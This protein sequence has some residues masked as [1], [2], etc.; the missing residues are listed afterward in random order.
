MRESLGRSSKERKA[1]YSDSMSLKEL[2]GPG[3]G[4]LPSKKKGM[5]HGKKGR[6]RKS[7]PTLL[8]KRLPLPVYR[9]LQR[10]GKN[11][12]TLLKQVNR[13]VKASAKHVLWF[14]KRLAKYQKQLKRKKGKTNRKVR[15]EKDRTFL[16]GKTR[17]ECWKE[18]QKRKTQLWQVVVDYE[19]KEKE[20]TK[21]QAQQAR[22]AQLEERQR[23]FQ[24]KMEYLDTWDVLPQA[25]K[26]T[27][28]SLSH[29]LYQRV[30][31]DPPPPRRSSRGGEEPRSMYYNS[32]PMTPSSMLA[33]KMPNWRRNIQ[34]AYQSTILS[35]N[36]AG[37]PEEHPLVKKAARRTP[38]P[39][40]MSWISPVLEQH[41]DRDWLCKEQGDDPMPYQVG[42]LVLY[43]P[44]AHASFLKV[45]PDHVGHSNSD[46]PESIKLSRKPLWEQAMDAQSRRLAARSRNQDFVSS[47]AAEG[48]STTVAE[49][50]GSRISS[51][52][53]TQTETPAR[54]IPLTEV[55]KTSRRDAN[56]DTATRCDRA[57][58]EHPIESATN[59]RQSQRQRERTARGKRG[60]SASARITQ[61]DADTDLIRRT[62]ELQQKKNETQ[63]VQR[64]SV[65]QSMSEASDTSHPLQRQVTKTRPEKRGR[66]AD[67]RLTTHSGESNGSADNGRE[68]R[69]SRFQ[70]TFKVPTESVRDLFHGAAVSAKIGTKKE[71]ML[72]L[73]Q[74]KKR[75]KLAPRGNKLSSKVKGRSKVS[76]RKIKKLVIKVGSKR[77]ELAV[78]KGPKKQHALKRRRVESDAVDSSPDGE[79]EIGDFP[80]PSVPLE[81]E[82]EET[83]LDEEAAL[84]A[85][86]W[87]SKD[88]LNGID[89]DLGRYPILCR[90]EQSHAEFPQDPHKKK[91]DKH[92]NVTWIISQTSASRMPKEPIRLCLKLKPLTPVMPPVAKGDSHKLPLPPKFSVVTFPSSEAQSFLIPFAEAF[93]KYHSLGVGDTVAG[94]MNGKVAQ[95]AS[96]GENFGSFQLADKVKE[97]RG[98]LQQLEKGDTSSVGKCLGIDSASLLYEEDV[99]FLVEALHLFMEN[100]SLDD[101]GEIENLATLSL[102]DILRSCFPLFNGIGIRREAF[103]RKISY[104]SAWDLDHKKKPSGSFGESLRDLCHRHLARGVQSYLPMPLRVR[105]RYL[106]LDFLESRPEAAGFSKAIALEDA[107]SYN[108]AV[109]VAMYFDRILARLNNGK[110][111]EN[112]YYTSVESILSDIQAVMINCRVYNSRDSPLVTVCS[113]LVPALKKSVALAFVNSVRDRARKARTQDTQN[114]SDSNALQAISAKSIV[115]CFDVLKRRALTGKKIDHCDDR[116]RLDAIMSGS[117][118]SVYPTGLRSLPTFEDMLLPRIDVGSAGVG[119]RGVRRTDDDEAISTLS[120]CLFLPPWSVDT[121]IDNPKQQTWADSSKLCLELVRLRLKEQYYSGRSELISEL[122]E[123]YLI[124]STSVLSGPASRKKKGISAQKVAYHLHSLSTKTSLID[125][126]DTVPTDN[127]EFTNEDE[128]V[129][130]SRLERAQKLYT[131]VG[132]RVQLLSFLF[133]SLNAPSFRLCRPFLL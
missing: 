106:I 133:L 73:A 123:A 50:G 18:L 77:I 64:S 107:P 47:S 65:K 76:I 2:M 95:I 57:A 26:E 14:E 115:R 79:S 101:Q 67:A 68:A 49:E 96:L 127:E 92:G 53:P 39:S 131:M 62:P 93:A 6:P 58:E 54:T 100:E 9:E 78:P 28:L 17:Q 27:A 120:E 7:G 98:L 20:A 8:D 38:P 19:R 31:K 22:Q 71:K 51:E 60:H 84:E 132:S 81:D 5:Q 117:I 10:I 36:S 88:W 59:I 46:I 90:I 12:K 85:E 89:S 66:S 114:D 108:C 74:M 129:L 40:T 52:Q 13:Q 128:K 80:L 48:V 112:I 113:S 55:T 83:D 35:Q 122:R 102:L 29:D 69:T 16:N 97:I 56:N 109:P 82:P 34:L 11:R 75:A 130:L 23:Q 33:S 37:Q 121:L 4:K 118:P 44:G 72:K 87:W 111:C 21:S 41:L 61:K 63:A 105:I 15:M 25:Y 116:Y 103:H 99:S 32:L 45:H 119:T 30:P 104:V 70:G 110:N 1:T 91:V 86:P 43:Y 125:S 24:T 124:S 126:A 3:R 94:L 42:S